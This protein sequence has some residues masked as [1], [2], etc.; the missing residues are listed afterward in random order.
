MANGTA[1]KIIKSPISKLPFA[2]SDD[3][4]DES[5]LYT[6]LADKNNAN[7][8]T[9]EQ[10]RLGL[11]R[12]ISLKELKN[13]L[14]GKNWEFPNFIEIPTPIKIEK[15]LNRNM[16]PINPIYVKSALV[17][18]T[19]FIDP[20]RGFVHVCERGEDNEGCVSRQEIWLSS[21]DTTLGKTQY[22]CRCFKDYKNNP[23]IYKDLLS[24][25][26]GN[27]NPNAIMDKSQTFVD[28][29]KIGLYE[30]AMGQ[31][32]QGFGPKIAEVLE[33]YPPTAPGV[34]ERYEI[35]FVF[36][37]IETN[38]MNPGSFIYE[39]GNNIITGLVTQY[40]N[41]NPN[42]PKIQETTMRMIQFPTP[43]TVEWT[44]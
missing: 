1:Q 24:N 40:D 39:S 26:T 3:L 10:Q 43:D 31:Y 21:F 33:Y 7:M 27:H 37:S 2:S 6:V 22:T 41:Y 17:T 23:Q 16:P 9:E 36:G 19:Y 42:D 25:T 18:F 44:V 30:S 15:N 38:Y 8:L 11:D 35:S 28:Y 12:R 34:I 32:R 13:S 20:M 29:D 5:F 4:N 14:F